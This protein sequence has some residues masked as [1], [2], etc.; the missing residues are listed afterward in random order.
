MSTLYEAILECFR[1]S[2]KVMTIQEV[3]DY[4][5]KNY[6]QSWKD[7]RTT[8]ADMTHENYDGNSSSTVPYEFR[9][10][11]RVGRGRYELIPLQHENR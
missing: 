8:L 6:S 7:I 2:Q 1:T 10:L 3:S 5:D 4:I 11:K 9:R